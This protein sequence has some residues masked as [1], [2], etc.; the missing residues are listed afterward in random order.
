MID[1]IIRKIFGINKNI[2]HMNLTLDVFELQQ[3]LVFLL[4]KTQNTLSE[5]AVKRIGWWEFVPKK[6]ICNQTIGHINRT[7]ILFELHQ[8]LISI[9]RKMQN[10]FSE[11]AVKKFG[12]WEFIPKK[13]IYHQTID[14][15]NR[16]LNIFEL[17]QYLISLL[18][19]TQNTFSEPAL[20]NFGWW[21]FFPK[22]KIVTKP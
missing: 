9:L 5:P 7:L 21:E 14:H 11:L 18:R 8:Y 16:T 1:C 3:C 4:R 17:Y 6:E 22:R 15:I 20:T 12:W 10:T 13:E 19:K 2:V